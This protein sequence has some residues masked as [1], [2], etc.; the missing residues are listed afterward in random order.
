MPGGANL[1][2]GCGN[3]TAMAAIRE[4]SLD[5]FFKRGKRERKSAVRGLKRSEGKMEDGR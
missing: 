3:P 5:I 2:V 1:G 4:V